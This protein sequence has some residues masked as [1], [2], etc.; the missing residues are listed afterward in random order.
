MCAEDEA[1]VR[2]CSLGVVTRIWRENYLR[3]ASV[4]VNTHASEVCRKP[5]LY[6]AKA[7]APPSERKLR[8]VVGFAAPPAAGT[9]PACLLTLGLGISL[10]SCFGEVSVCP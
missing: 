6:H 10:A 8:S 5:G 3:W 4:A 1:C 2:K 7:L 9:M